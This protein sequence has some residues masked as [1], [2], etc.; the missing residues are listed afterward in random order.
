[1]P[2]AD[3][4][5]QYFW[6]KNHRRKRRLK[7]IEY[8]GGECVDC[9]KEEDENE[10]IKLE[11][12]HVDPCNKLYTIASHISHSWEKLK[13]ELDKCELRCVP[14]HKAKTYDEPPF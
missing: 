9:G 7:A 11:F 3:P 14:C 5:K 1:M 8:L 2:Y 4:L 6:A 12:D 10:G 13:T